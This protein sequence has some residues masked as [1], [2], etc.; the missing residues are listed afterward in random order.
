MPKEHANCMVICHALTGLA[1]VEDWWGPLVG[2]GLVFDLTLYFIFCANT[3]G[4]PYGCASPVPINP[5]TEK[6]GPEFPSTKMT[7]DVNL[8]QI[9]LNHFKTLC[10]GNQLGCNSFESWFGR[11]QVLPKPAHNNGHQLQ[12]Q[13]IPTKHQDQATWNAPSELHTIKSPCQIFSAQFDDVNHERG[14]GP[15]L[16][17]IPPDALV[18]AINSDG[19]FTLVEQQE[20]ANSIPDARL[21]VV[22][23]TDGH[24][25][26]LLEFEQINQYV[27]LHLCQLLPHLYGLL[28]KSNNNKALDFALVA[29]IEAK[30][31]KTI[32]C[33]EAGGSITN[34]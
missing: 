33:S 11:K 34:S 13:V 21:V 7:D 19:L 28:G 12:S 14:D 1:D 5:K 15:A 24:N 2:P 27:I 16:L 9:L 8:Q 18:I 23:S 3:R 10:M 17:K 30:L 32:I 26:F 6:W 31:L 29:S 4:S 22:E 20:L 25:G